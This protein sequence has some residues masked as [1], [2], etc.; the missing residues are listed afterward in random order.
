MNGCIYEWNFKWYDYTNYVQYL[1]ILL[2]IWN[3]Y[4]REAKLTNFWM[5]KLFV[6]WFKFKLK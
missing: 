1:Q 6:R 5:N 2:N 4:A 3:A